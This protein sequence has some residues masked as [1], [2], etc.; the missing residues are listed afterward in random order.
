LPLLPTSLIP[1]IR[2]EKQLAGENTKMKPTDAEKL[3][4]SGDPFEQNLEHLH[5]EDS[6]IGTDL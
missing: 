6:D 1:T 5:G 3:F 2:K 4:L